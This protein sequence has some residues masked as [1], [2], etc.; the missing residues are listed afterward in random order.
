M[1]GIGPRSARRRTSDGRNRNDRKRGEGVPSFVAR[2]VEGP[3]CSEPETMTEAGTR[4]E[5]ERR[6]LHHAR[7]AARVKEEPVFRDGW[8]E[9]FE[10]AKHLFD[11]RGEARCDA[12]E[13]PNEGLVQVLGLPD[14]ET[15]RS[16][17]RAG[18]GSEPDRADARAVS[19]RGTRALAI[20]SLLRR[21][22]SGERIAVLR[23]VAGL[24][25]DDRLSATLSKPS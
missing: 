5:T 2:D 22:W 9:G 24:L 20:A 18:P 21:S 1:S 7:V 15:A 8:C 19:R 10:A 4:L 11:H 6:R 13:P 3:T 23:T 17:E 14:D 25:D 12:T 16:A